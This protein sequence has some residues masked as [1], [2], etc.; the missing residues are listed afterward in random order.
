MHWLHDFMTFCTSHEL[1]LVIGN[2]LGTSLDPQLVKF[3]LPV[4]QFVLIVLPLFLLL[5][6]VRTIYLYS[7]GIA[8]RI[9]YSSQALK[10]PSLVPAG[11]LTF[12]LKYSA[13]QQMVVVGLG[14]LTL[15]LLY[16]SLELP[17]MIIDYVITPMNT[18]DSFPMMHFGVSL[19]RIDHLIALCLIF[20]LV[21]VLKG[22]VKLLLN[23]NR[24][25]LAERLLRR[26]RLSIYRRWRQ[27][28][29]YNRQTDVIPM[30]AQ[31][32]EPIGGFA[33]DIIS[34][35]VFQGGTFIVIITFMFLQ[36]PILGLAA[37]SLLPLQ[38]LL[39]PY[40]QRRVNALART[41]IQ[42]IRVLGRTL[43]EQ[44]LASAGSSLAPRQ[45][46][47]KLQEIR[48]VI[49]KWKYTMKALNNFLTALT[50][51][52]FYSIGGYLVIKGELTLGALVAVL[53]AFKD[54]S[55]PLRELFKYYQTLEDVRVR[56]REL[57]RFCQPPDYI[58]GFRSNE[59]NPIDQIG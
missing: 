54:F 22:V 15:P 13:R 20:L 4:F 40:F 49:F 10:N 34:Q 57:V 6:V 23:L 31:E 45:S 37:L 19:N 33:G 12:V 21:I 55:R 35:P 5:I 44:S 24:G 8:A 43:G 47:R 52:F 28:Q 18:K 46:F 2:L 30:I 48:W 36:N 3:L 11:M 50:P 29:T 32:V 53:A 17:K 1:I 41:R 42:E 56:Y 58:K 9:Q 39:I 16:A 25:R 27:G 38:L 51:F 59:T 14:L 7:C 26:L